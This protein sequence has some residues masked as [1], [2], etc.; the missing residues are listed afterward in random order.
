MTV[1]EVVGFEAKAYYNTGT[2]AT[3]TWVEMTR[4][5]DVSTPLSKSEADV[6]RRETR[7]KLARGAMIEAAV[8]IAYQYKKGTDA[9]FD[10]LLD[11]FLNGTPIQVAIMDQAIATSGA[12]GLR[13]VLRSDGIPLRATAR[14]LADVQRHSQADQRRGSRLARA[15][16]L[17]RHT[18]AKA[19]GKRQKEKVAAHA[20][21]NRGST[22]VDQSTH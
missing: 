8:E 18:V 2:D 13:G 11:S 15:A 4:C 19:N 14:R 5:K 3:P 16:G 21:P 6:S 17:V 12:Q 10:A 20:H 1:Q 9:V 7:F 22:D